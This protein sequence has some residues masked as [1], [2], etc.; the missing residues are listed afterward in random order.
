MKSHSTI[1]SIVFG[2]LFLNL[3]FESNYILYFLI[4]ISGASIFSNKVSDK[5]EQV[6]FFLAL[7]LSKIVPNILLILIFFLLL[8]PLAFLSKIFKAQ[9]DFKK[10]NDS[11]TMFVEVNKTFSKRSYERSW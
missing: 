9:T 11:N 2:F 1:L 10:V 6:W 7:I 4:I 8:T 3:F 5:I